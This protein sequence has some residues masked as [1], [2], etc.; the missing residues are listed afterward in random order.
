M[1]LLEMDYWRSAIL[2]AP[3]KQIVQQNSFDDIDVTFLPKGRRDEFLADPFGLWHEG[4]L[5]VFIES[6]DYRHGKG[7][8]DVLIYDD[9]FNLLERKEVLNEPWHLS[10]PNVFRYEGEIYM[11]PEAHKSGRLTLYKARSFP[12]GWEKVEAFDFPIGAIDAT[13]LYYAGRWWLFWTPP[14]PKPFRQSALHIA[15]ADELTGP[16]CDMGRF[17]ID[18]S[19]ARPAGTPFIDG[20][21][22]VLP[23]QD[24]SKTYGGGIRF[25][26]ISGLGLGHP[27]LYSGDNLPM[28]GRFVKK[29][30]DG[31]HTLSS[32]GNVTLIDFKKIK[33]SVRPTLFKLRRNLFK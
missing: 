12:D 25:L 33:R 24:C 23:V 20:K 2:H 17:L 26:R 6:Y 18:K 31:M 15:V 21:E 16:W 30:P 1:K 28:A 9:R 8:I 13:P 19:G 5:Y 4:K 14:S 7:V 3:M 32:V 22:V 27:D 11:L 10:Y 29:Y